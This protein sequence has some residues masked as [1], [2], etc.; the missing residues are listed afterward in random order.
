M[1]VQS[2]RIKEWVS[3]R[4]SIKEC[5]REREAAIKSEENERR[6][7]PKQAPT[8]TESRGVHDDIP[9]PAGTTQLNCAVSRDEALHLQNIQFLHD[10][11][12]VDLNMRYEEKAQ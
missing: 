7:V 2:Q 12:H 1:R 8:K 6:K 9:P 5:R 4:S 3:L 11:F 10:L